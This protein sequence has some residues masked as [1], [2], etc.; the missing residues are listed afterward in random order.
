[1]PT[2]NASEIKWGE[3]SLNSDRFIVGNV[4]SIDAESVEISAQSLT[5][6][7]VDGEYFK[8]PY[9]HGEIRYGGVFVKFT[10]SEFERL[11]NCAGL[12]EKMSLRYHE[13]LIRKVNEA[14]G[15]NFKCKETWEHNAREAQQN[16][17]WKGGL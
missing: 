16:A 9:F 8:K 7:K 11:L 1:M 17:F 3:I 5:P 6:I 12:V 13:L 14:W 2:F 4:R 10:K 15:T